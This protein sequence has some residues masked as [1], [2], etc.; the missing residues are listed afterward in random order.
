MTG[1]IVHRFKL[2]CPQCSYENT[3][4]PPKKEKVDT[5]PAIGYT[6]SIPV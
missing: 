6:K 3:I 5:S 4:Y 2:C 1:A